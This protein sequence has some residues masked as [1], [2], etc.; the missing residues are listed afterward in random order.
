MRIIFIV[1]LL[2]NISFATT[3]S[4]TMMTIA[5]AGITP[6]V[7]SNMGSLIARQVSINSTYEK[8]RDEIENKKQNITNIF[9]L[10]KLILL[11]LKEINEV[12]DLKKGIKDVK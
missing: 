9:T 12:I 2:T 4:L 5:T 10:D 1:L 8:V 6:I 11:E 7:T 3:W